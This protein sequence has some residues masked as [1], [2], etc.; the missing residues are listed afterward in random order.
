MY[1]DESNTINCN[2]FPIA[3]CRT[4]LDPMTSQLHWCVLGKWALASKDGDLVQPQAH[5]ETYVSITMRNNGRVMLMHYNIAW[6]SN[7]FV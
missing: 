7:V 3:N 4:N 1:L 5:G 6:I 2:T